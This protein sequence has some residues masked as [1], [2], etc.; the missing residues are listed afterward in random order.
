MDRLRFGAFSGK[1]ADL[2]VR[3]RDYEELAHFV[4][5]AKCQGYQPDVGRV[6]EIPALQVGELH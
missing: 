3:K 4:E 2:P 1:V 5:T 6:R